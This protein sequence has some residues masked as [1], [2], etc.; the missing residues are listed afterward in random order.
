[1]I[2]RQI[3]ADT[4]KPKPHWNGQKQT[5]PYIY[6]GRQHES[7]GIETEWKTPCTLTMQ[8]NSDFNAGW[9]EMVQDSTFLFGD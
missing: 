3:E 4:D 8:I 9:R 1:M 6:W 7:R 2:D 5:G